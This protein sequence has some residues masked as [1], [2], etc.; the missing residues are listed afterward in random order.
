MRKKNI[1]EFQNWFY[2]DPDCIHEIG[3]IACWLFTSK[4]YYNAIYDGGVMLVTIDD[5]KVPGIDENNTRNIASFF[6]EILTSIARE[7]FNNRYALYN[8]L[9]D[10]NIPM[11]ISNHKIE[12]IKNRKIIQAEFDSLGRLI[13]LEATV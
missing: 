3:M 11:K 9:I 6:P 12:G 2:D 10:R 4:S 8:Y 7:D 5:D 13:W 1:E